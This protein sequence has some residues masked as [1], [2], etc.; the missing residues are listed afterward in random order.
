MLIYVFIGALGNKGERMFEIKLQ[1]L[2]PLYSDLDQVYQQEYSGPYEDLSYRDDNCVVIAAIK[3]GRITG[4]GRPVVMIGTD[5]ALKTQIRRLYDVSQDIYYMD[6]LE[7]NRPSAVSRFL[8]QYG[9]AAMPYFTQIINLNKPERELHANIRKSY[10]SLCNK[11][12]VGVSIIPVLK[13][14]HIEFHGR[15]TRSDKTWKLQTDMVS[16]G[17]AFVLANK[18]NTAAALFYHNKYSA[19]YACSATRGGAAHSLIW[20]AIK[21]LKRKGCRVL[22]L[23]EQV[24]FGDEKLIGISKFKFGFGGCTK[25][26][27]IIGEKNGRDKKM[28]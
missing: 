28:H 15:Q 19:Y 20:E 27:L 22:E 9:L 14:T 8:I 26:R 5:K 17:Q 18:Q 10:K 12:S 7:H 11:D 23:G 21:I 2:T 13:E 25:T 24:L 3:D 16:E 6:F 4:Y 1:Q